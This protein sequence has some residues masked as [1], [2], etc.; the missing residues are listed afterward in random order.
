MILGFIDYWGTQKNN[1]V[2]SGV[3]FLDVKWDILEETT[4]NKKSLPNW[5][6]FSS[7]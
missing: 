3:L 5:K 1:G 4:R 6:S 7:V 2:P